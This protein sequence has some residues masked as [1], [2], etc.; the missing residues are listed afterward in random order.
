MMPRSSVPYWISDWS[1]K[2]VTD[3]ILVAIPGGGLRSSRVAATGRK[4]VVKSTTSL[5][6]SVMKRGPAATS[7]I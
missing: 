2:S 7:A 1:S 5:R 6:S 4:V 3:L